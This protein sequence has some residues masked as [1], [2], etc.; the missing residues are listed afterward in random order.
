M[1]PTAGTKSRPA[2]KPRARWWRG[3]NAAL[4]QLRAQHDGQTVLLVSHGFVVRCLRYLIDGLSE[5][6]FFA[7]ARIPNGHFLTRQLP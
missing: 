7:A 5:A 3:S 4:Q 2:P 1:P 6:E